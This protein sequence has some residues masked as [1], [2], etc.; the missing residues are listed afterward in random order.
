MGYKY[1][2]NNVTHEVS[3]VYTPK[4]KSYYLKTEFFFK[5]IG[6]SRYRIFLRYIFANN[7]FVIVCTFNLLTAYIRSDY[8]DIHVTLEFINVLVFTRI[9]EI[10][11]AKLL[12]FYQILD[13]N[14]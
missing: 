13:A 7:F 9:F 3:L 8:I 4:N 5:K 10:N 11:M 1:D 12:I 2:S 14:F 6:I